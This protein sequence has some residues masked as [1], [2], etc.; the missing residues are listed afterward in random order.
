MSDEL[1]AAI[2]GATGYSGREL[3][4]WLQYHPVAKPVLLTGSR[5][6][7]AELA[8]FAP[9]LPADAFFPFRYGENFVEELLDAVNGKKAQVVFLATEIENAVGLTPELLD[10]GVVVIDLSAGF[11]L[12][13]PA[14]Y[15][16][17][18]SLIHPNPTLLQESVY[19]LPE[20]RRDEIAR[21]RLIANPG[22]YPTSIL[23]GL[24]PLCEYIDWQAPVVCDSK[25]GLTGA[26]RNADYI[27]AEIN[28]N[29]L[30]YKLGNHRHLPEI[31]QGLGKQVGNGIPF[32]F[33]PHLV[34][35]NRGIL[36]TCYFRAKA[37]LEEGDL[38]ECFGRRYAESPFV[39]LL[40]SGTLPQVQ[41]VAHTNRC[42]IAVVFNRE[43]RIV[44]VVSVIDNLVKG[45]AGQ[46]I[47]NMNIRFGLDEATGLAGTV[48]GRQ[49]AVGSR[50]YAVGRRQSAGGRKSVIRH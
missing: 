13:D 30:A 7:L 3:V 23:L 5:K 31:L 18:Y 8:R 32:A 48:S 26:G 4:R 21:A 45:A 20:Y 34:P 42:E 25:S 46:A 17:W 11:R 6:S 19:G 38:R 2:I 37:G 33:S 24:L 35:M 47:Q 14:L 44:T 12:K 27:F 1:R 39:S 22:C 16:Q 41:V 49:P 50:Q 15:R 10:Q 28:E 40:A 43:S 36:S 29:C 9:S